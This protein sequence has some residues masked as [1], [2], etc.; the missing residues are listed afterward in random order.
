[1]GRYQWQ[2]LGHLMDSIKTGETPPATLTAAFNEQHPE[3]AAVLNQAIAELTRRIT[4]AVVQAYDF[5]GCR[6]IIDVGG[7]YGELLVAILKANPAACGV[8]FEV[9]RVIEQG[10]SIWHVPTWRTAVSAWLAT[11]SRLCRAEEM[12]TS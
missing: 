3:Q 12:P 10:R 7:G 5:T 1:M 9:P 4:P 6:R 2:A 11:S 8:L